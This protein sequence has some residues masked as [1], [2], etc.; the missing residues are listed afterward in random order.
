MA[1]CVY[2]S[3]PLH[4]C[5]TNAPSLKDSSSLIF[6]V[7]PFSKRIF[8]MEND[9]L[10]DGASASDVKSFSIP[11]VFLREKRS[12]LN[13]PYLH[14]SPFSAPRLSSSVVKD[15]CAKP[16]D[17]LDVATIVK[18]AMSAGLRGDWSQRRLVNDVS[19]DSH[20]SMESLCVQFP[21]D[22]FSNAKASPCSVPSPK[23]TNETVSS[24]GKY[25]PGVVH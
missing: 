24:S 1:A 15:I 6:F 5:K 25:L 12:H 18:L 20:S 4:R 7:N 14:A 21:S 3:F 10:N 23:M 17:S 8:T 22:S 19:Q 11:V 16:A 2:Q 9:N 13:T